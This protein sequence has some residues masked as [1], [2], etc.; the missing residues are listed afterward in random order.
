[1]QRDM[2]VTVGLAFT[3]AT[4]KIMSSTRQTQRVELGMVAYNQKLL[5]ASGFSRAFS[6][7]I[8]DWPSCA[9]HEIVNMRGSQNIVIPRKPTRRIIF[10]LHQGA[11]GFGQCDRAAG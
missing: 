5:L 6:L 4:H 9:D 7:L 11:P 1:M 10:T 8:G 2:L 3:F